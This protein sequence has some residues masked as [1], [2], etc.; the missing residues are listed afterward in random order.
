MVAIIVLCA[1]SDGRRYLA[2]AQ[3][4]LLKNRISV[5]LP[6]GLDSLPLPDECLGNL[7]SAPFHVMRKTRA[8][9]ATPVKTDRCYRSVTI[10]V[11]QSAVGIVSDFYLLIIPIPAVWTLQLP[12]RKKIGIIGIF[13]TGLLACMASCLSLWLRIR[14]RT[15][16][17][18]TWDAIDPLL[19]A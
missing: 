3:V 12:L 9:D 15:A 2:A 19:V 6:I 10:G 13:M 16:N 17:D 14:L 18:V 8:A 5:L 4:S 11:V 7:A 1:P